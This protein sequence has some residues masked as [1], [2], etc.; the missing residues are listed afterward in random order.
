M[1]VAVNC[2]PFAIFWGS[3]LLDKGHFTL[4]LGLAPAFLIPIERSMRQSTPKITM[5]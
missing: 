5:S 3:L 4:S 1:L 2:M